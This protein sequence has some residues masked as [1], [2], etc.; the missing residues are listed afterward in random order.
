MCV[1]TRNVQ[2]I[3]QNRS[4]LSQNLVFLLYNLQ[5]LRSKKCKRYTGALHKVNWS[6]D[7]SIATLKEEEKENIPLVYLIYNYDYF[8]LLLSSFDILGIIIQKN[9]MNI[10]KK[11]TFYWLLVRD[12][13]KREQREVPGPVWIDWA[14]PG[15]GLKWVK[16]HIRQFWKPSFT[17]NIY[18]YF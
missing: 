18:I 6:R 13:L 17:F 16:S 5:T 1:Y 12:S 8:F 7:I 14:G 9:W 4:G 15:T 11:N 10:H 3:L 2:C